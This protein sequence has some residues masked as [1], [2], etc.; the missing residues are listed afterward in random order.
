MGI[1]AILFGTRHIDTTEHQN[2]MIFAIAIESI[3]KLFAFIA[4]GA[5]I[6]F[7]MV[8]GV[9]DLFEKAST[10]PDIA[11][12]FSG[13]LDGGRWLTLTFLAAL[14]IILLPR[15]F[16]VMIV[17]NASSMEIK[18]ARWLFP[19]YLLLINIFV[20]PIAVAGLLLLPP[21]S[22]GDTFVIALPVQ[23]GSSLFAMIAFIG[24]LSASTAMVIVETIALSIM[25]CNNLVVPILLRRHRD[26][27]Q[28][29]PDMGRLLILVRRAAIALILI[30]ASS[31]YWMVGSTAALA[32]VGLISFAAVAQLAPAFFGGVLWRRGTARGAMAG[33]MAGFALWFYTLLFPS[34]ADA[35]W[36]DPRFVENGPLGI[37]LLKPRTLFYMEFEPLTHGVLW[38]LVANVCAY[39][40]V[41]LMR[42]PTPVE[43]MGAS[44]FVSH[45]IHAPTGSRLWLWRTT[46]TLGRLEETVSR[47]LGASRTHAAFAEFLAQRNQAPS[48]SL[49]AD[50]RLLRF[51]EHLLARAIGN[52]SSRL[53]IALML[54]RHSAQPR[55]AMRLLDDAT[56]AIQY[57]RDLLQSAI[58]NV[59]QGIGVFDADMVLVCWNNRFEELLQIEPEL[60]RIGAPMREIVS[61]FLART[62]DGETRLDARVRAL[63][64]VHETFRE[65]FSDEGPV[66]EFRSSPMPG[67]GVVA[68]V[69]DQTESVKSADTL[70]KINESL[71]RRVEER[72]AELRKLNAELEAARAE[73]E[74]ANLGK[75]RF[76]AAASHDI[77]QPLN[78][79]KLFVASLVERHQRSADGALV[80]N[81]DASLGSVEEIISAL[82]D[83]SRLDAGAQKPDI[84]PL[85]IDEIFTALALEF[86]PAAR[87]KGLKLKVVHCNA[88][89]LSD[90]KLLRRV[91]QNLLSNAIKYAR[92][93][94]VLMGCR[95]QGK[96]IRVD[97]FDTG[98]GIPLAMQDKIFEEFARL[99]QGGDGPP[100]LGLGLSIVERTARLLGSE[101]K[102]RSVVGKGSGFSITVPLS[103]AP[104]IMPARQGPGRKRMGLGNVTSVLVIDNETQILEGMEALIGG[105]GCTVYTAKSGAAALK[106]LQPH[107]AKIDVVIVDY[108]LGKED[109]LAVVQ[110]LRLM[111]RR[112]IS[113]ILVTADGSAQVQA[114][115]MASDVLYMRKPI[116]PAKLRAAM[117]QLSIGAAAAE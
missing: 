15:Q 46:I 14:A 73:A 93:G 82:L 8:G 18:R 3:V 50:I 49:E 79:A 43:R 26:K 86:G 117:A 74:A 60:A 27:Q 36:I 111:A 103:E 51:A 44:E 71:E 109:G 7:V 108:H 17:E 25:V 41:S 80:R 48:P 64:Q 72:T 59:G 107:Q 95:R 112:P 54:E 106:A 105:W 101:I 81:L 22:D 89:V 114:R 4:A 94:G 30:L 66:L 68:T 102:L 2:G 78:A 13:S 88:V 52:S 21:G 116:K 97:V 29:L 28:A 16:H 83:I 56:A 61:A 23:A 11:N 6:T 37:G 104:F 91:L 33:I 75:T 115:A 42:A 40:A 24:G 67:G 100:G 10:N 57:N 70:Q 31:Y 77:L 85:R 9:P 65:R 47:Y 32:Q 34:F 84:A 1:F 53:V 76:I 63:A 113:A 96:R 12:L 87:S 62:D 110:K 38:S 35:G 39:I 69:T 45:D 58:D 5:F 98:P 99:E 20:I 92:S 90:R 19:L 55:G